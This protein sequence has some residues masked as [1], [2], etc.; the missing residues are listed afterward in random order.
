MAN[1]IAKRQSKK[2]FWNQI[3]NFPENEQVQII[4]ATAHNISVSIKDYISL[5]K[6]NNV[7]KKIKLEMLNKQNDYY[8]SNLNK[9]NITEEDRKRSSFGLAD[10]RNKLIS[11]NKWDSFVKI[12][13]PVIGTG[14]VIS[15]IK[16]IKKK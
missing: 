16:I 10:I 7:R 14:L 2:S 4:I 12:I 6:E 3:K 8:L 9:E 11:M 1:E 15:A 5:V 13:V